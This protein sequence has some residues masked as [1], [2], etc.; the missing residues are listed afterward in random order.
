MKPSFALDL[1]PDGIR[2]L[3]RSRGGWLPVGEVSLDDP[4]MAGAL[5]YLRSTA[6]GLTP[7]GLSTKL[8]LP[9]D[10]I[11][12]TTVSAPGPSVAQRRE[13]IAVALEGMTPYKVDDLVFDWSGTGAEVKVAV[14]ARE[15]LDEAEGFA[16]EHRFNPVS[17]VTVP[18][19]G[20]FAGEPFFGPTRA[21][22]GQLPEGEKV[23]RDQDPVRIVGP[24]TPPE[25]GGAP[26]T[27]AETAAEAAPQVPEPT[28]GERDAEPGPKAQPEP[29]AASEAEAAAEMPD[30]RAPSPPPSVLADEI[31]DPEADKPR[32]HKARAPRKGKAAKESS[33]TEPAP[34]KTPAREGAPDDAAAE[35]T[36]VAE[37][38]PEEAT[39]AEA[40][41]EFPT[42]EER[43][44]EAAE[45][46]DLDRSARPA[47]GLATNAPQGM[48]APDMTARATPGLA[49]PE[50]APV[51]FSSRRQLMAEAPAT[52]GADAAPKLGSAR[53]AAPDGDIPAPRALK[54]A[55]AP[56]TRAETGAEPVPRLRP[57]ASPQA[58]PRPA[59][60]ISETAIP[61]PLRSRI[62]AQAS[63]AVESLTNRGGRKSGRKARAKTRSTRAKTPPPAVTAPAVTAPAVTAPE[64]EPVSKPTAKSA[65]LAATRAATR[66]AVGEEP[67]PVPQAA[68]APGGEAPKDEAEA[69]TVFGARRFEEQYGKP[70]YLGL[71]LTLILIVLLGLAG[72]WSAMV[73]GR[74]D[75]P[76][77]P[78]ETAT[79]DPTSAPASAPEASSATAPT[80]TSPAATTAA[81]DRPA[82]PAI[83]EPAPLPELAPPATDLATDLAAE[84]PA[85]SG[86]APAETAPASD[87][88]TPEAPVAT[89]TPSGDSAPN[90][91]AAAADPATAD[92]ATADAPAAGADSDA[93]A[94]ATGEAPA[95]P[96]TAPRTIRQTDGGVPALPAD[97]VT[98]LVPAD[99]LVQQ[100]PTAPRN[101]VAGQLGEVFVGHWAPGVSAPAVA[102]LPQLATMRS[103]ADF[104]A[105]VNPP[106]YG[107]VFAL[108]AKGLVKATPDGAVTPQ[109]VVVYAA[110]PPV[111]PPARP[112]SAPAGDASAGTPA[113]DAPTAA[114]TAALEA[115]PGAAPAADPALAGKRPKPRPASAAPAD[116]T[117][118]DQGALP[119][120]ADPRLAGVRP[121][122]RPADLIPDTSAADAA[123]A[124]AAAAADAAVSALAVPASPV[125]EDR[126]ADLEQSVAAAVAAANR[127]SDPA[128]AE[129]DG[130]GDSV[131]TAPSIP[132]SAS[133]AR[134]AT[135]KKALTMNRASLLGV[136]GSASN[137]KALV[138]LPSGRIIK[139]KVGDRVD[140]GKVV[141]LGEHEL[142]YVKNGRNH[143]LKMP[144]G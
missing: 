18:P 95:A 55:T 142:H 62:A 74:N 32:R 35:K 120:P 73:L 51:P 90:A 85:P 98:R 92:P 7:R 82:A 30:A 105:P 86:A 33:G 38:T 9:P 24:A 141:A 3:H 126:P 57:A 103:D 70:R 19:A 121:K 28:A 53:Q 40:T 6:L 110:A 123:S 124:A 31:V 60:V 13:Q 34:D 59:E 140:G 84:A 87:G 113:A 94:V 68:G 129:S 46:A 10:Q 127:S 12:Y 136:V 130:A 67:T 49:A 45:A 83:V 101:P 111:V 114:P 97:P 4:D 23:E 137:R 77:A 64:P 112:G 50:A 117:A 1:S 93:P 15:T 29:E 99:I 52:P 36:A 128:V 69:M 81:T 144:K 14:V 133:V 39:P 48:A 22:K 16:V 88:A 26:G 134:R 54:A 5:G 80:A 109:G 115:A 42:A 116:S 96:S 122:P 27:T 139:V 108:N 72:L 8:V 107:T 61:E 58:A 79:V 132:T 91:D 100:A 2:L 43:A 21:A 75:S 135:V 118:P 65:A 78:V 63:S 66:A 104:T 106:P 131:S 71:I 102:P 44:A 41:P 11:L 76:P 37:A 89:Q 125:P 20:A 25:D 138:R 47:P 56:E 119:P 143:I 17:F